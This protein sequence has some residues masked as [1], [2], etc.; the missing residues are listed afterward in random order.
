[1]DAPNN[2]TLEWTVTLS[3]DSETEPK[4]ATLRVTDALARVFARAVLVNKGDSY[5]LSFTSVLA[6]LVSGTD[7]VSNWLRENLGSYGAT[8][9]K[10]AGARSRSFDVPSLQRMDASSL[11]KQLQASQSARRA[12]EKAQEIMA[13]LGTSQ[14]LDIKHVAAAYPILQSWHESDFQS[15]GIDR[16]AWCRALGGYMATQYP[17]EKWYWRKYADRASPVPLTSFSADIYTERDLLEIDRSVDALALLIASARTDTPLSIGIFGEWGSGKSFFMRHLRKRIWTLASRQE[18]SAKNWVEKRKTGKATAAD[19]P[20]YYGR[21]A[22][23]EFNAWHYNEGNVVA[24]LVDHLFR[25]LKVYPGDTDAELD[26]KRAEVLAQIVGA[27]DELQQAATA[28]DRAT[29]EVNDARAEVQRVTEAAKTVRAQVDNSAQNVEDSRSQAEQVRRDLDDAIARLKTEIKPVDTEAFIAVALS[30]VVDS[31]AVREAKQMTDTMLAAFSDWQDFARSLLSRRGLAVVALCLLVPLAV[32]FVTQANGLWAAMTG[33]VVTG[34]AS[35]QHVVSFVRDRRKQFEEKLKELKTE[36]ERRTAEKQALL[37]QRKKEMQ[38][39]WDEKLTALR[40]TLEEQRQALR[41]SEKKAAD[42]L[43]TL[44]TRTKELDT[45]IDERTSA[46]KKLLALE[47]RLKQLSNALLLDEFIKNRSGTDE[48]KKQLGF[49]ALVRR[50]F[51]RLSD[52]IAKANDDWRSPKSE[53]QDR[54]SINRIVL[55][56]DDLDRCKVET[57]IHVLEAVHLLLAFPLFVCVVAVDPR[58]I[59]DCLKQK[60]EDLFSVKKEKANLPVTVGDYLEK[61]FQI[62]IWMSPIESRQRA[63]LVKAL[64]GKTAAPSETSEVLADDDETPSRLSGGS[65]SLRDALVTDGFA[66]IVEKAEK[67][68]DPLK[69]TPEEARFVDEIAPL[70]SDRPRALK[71]FVNTYRLLKASLSNVDRENFVSKDPSSSHKICISQLAFFTGQPRLAP[72]LVRQL[73]S[74]NGADTLGAWLETQNGEERKA[75]E[76]A[77][78]RFPE[79]DRIDLTKFRSWLPDTSKY[80]FHRDHGEADVLKDAP[81]HPTGP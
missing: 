39:S 34:T 29:T 23:V 65:P 1:M 6:G 80:L 66:E 38:T 7:S 10:I 8:G 12:I 33:I 67:K 64:L 27:K 3:Y 58:W 19:E 54:P 48:Y 20:L 43:Q 56:I 72:M 74:A 60:R 31:T 32:W 52:L 25:N 73:A 4:G 76:P 15:L 17:D 59:E 63:D 22:Q 61:I 79:I 9:E 49:L 68:P 28:I 57:V 70:L 81:S 42:A 40:A 53:N 13:E 21:V 41:E 51:E 24:S 45:K 16:L 77:L 78:K 71:R 47:T 26:E 44:A 14:A 69:I 30:P 55:Y 36:E 37:E 35:I 46:E 11:P 2:P 75:L 5:P 50:D 62:P 18:D